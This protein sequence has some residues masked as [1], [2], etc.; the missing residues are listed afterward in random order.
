MVRNTRTQRLNYSWNSMQQFIRYT[1]VPVRVKRTAREQEWERA[2]KISYRQSE[3]ERKRGER[4]E[5]TEREFIVR[6][7]I[8]LLFKNIHFWSTVFCSLSPS[9]YLFDVC[10]L[11]CRY[12]CMTNTHPAEINVFLSIVVVIVVVAALLKL[13]VSVDYT[14]GQQTYPTKQHEC[15]VIHFI[16]IFQK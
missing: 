11:W 13:Y 3:R 10:V 6:H 4:G 2:R 16:C 5:R 1:N 14:Y 8:Y 7:P 15:P 12:V 9:C